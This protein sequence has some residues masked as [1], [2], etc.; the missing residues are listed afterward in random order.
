MNSIHQEALTAT[1]GT[2][3]RELSDELNRVIN[4]TNPK[5]HEA[6]NLLQA[7][8]ANPPFSAPTSY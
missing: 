4:G 5:C 6:K 3:E 1:L 7:S 2:K 8:D